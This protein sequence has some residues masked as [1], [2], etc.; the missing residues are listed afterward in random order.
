MRCGQFHYG[1]WVGP[2]AVSLT[3]YD[4]AG[5]QIKDKTTRADQLNGVTFRGSFIL[6][7]QAE[8]SI[9]AQPTDGFKPPE[10]GGWKQLAEPRFDVYEVEVSRVANHWKVGFG[11]FVNAKIEDYLF[12]KMSCADAESNTPFAHFKMP[13]SIN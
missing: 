3:K 8:N 11:D 13:W 4:H 7:A 12:P 1:L 9:V 6:S 10:W 5:S 2:H